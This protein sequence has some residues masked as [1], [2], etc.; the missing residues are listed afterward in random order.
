MTTH[1]HHLRH[2]VEADTRRAA[3]AYAQLCRVR[4]MLLDPDADEAQ[5]GRAAGHYLAYAQRLEGGARDFLAD[6][7]AW[8]RAEARR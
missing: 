7:V 8:D 6:E 2:E 5:L 4:E 3:Y 1:H